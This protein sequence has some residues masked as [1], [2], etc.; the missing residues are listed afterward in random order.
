[1]QQKMVE[2]TWENAS[3]YPNL[4]CFVI[5]QTSHWDVSRIHGQS[6]PRVVPL[7]TSH[8]DF[9]GPIEF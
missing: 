7:G 8:L 9:S 3:Y 1:M 6:H 5:V 4:W 2:F